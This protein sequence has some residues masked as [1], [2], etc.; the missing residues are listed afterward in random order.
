MHGKGTFY[1]TDASSY[2]GDYQHGRKHGQGTFTFPSQKYYEGEWFNGKQNGKGAL[3][4]S[5]NNI[6]KKG[7]WKDGVFDKPEND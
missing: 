6:L 7:L 5:S 1:W 3:F 4:D 2:H